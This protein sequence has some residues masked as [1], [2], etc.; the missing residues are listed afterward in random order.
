MTVAFDATFLMLMLDPSAKAPTDPQTG[1]VVAD[2]EAR[3]E[4]LIQTMEKNRRKII[5]PTPALSEVLVG[6]DAAGPDY[7][8]IISQHACFETVGFDVRAAVEVAAVTRQAID[9]GDKKSGLTEPWQKVKYDRQIVGIAKVNGASS[10]YTDDQGIA[11]F[12]NHA[13]MEVIGIADLLLP[14]EDPQQS[15]NLD[16]D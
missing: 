6:A 15:L 13:G 8:S 9:D 10:I 3:I 14:P 7:L 11:T 5:I 12:A 2:A 16:F 4:Y 1:N